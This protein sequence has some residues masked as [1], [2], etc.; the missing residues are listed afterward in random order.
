MHR[1]NLL[2][3]LN[4]YYPTNI[5]EQESKEKIIAFVQQY[6]NCFERTLDIGHITA[7]SWLVSQDNTKALLTHHKKLN[8]WIQ[9]GGHCD[10]ESDTLAVA[11]KEAQEESGIEQIKPMQ[12]SIFDLGVHLIPEYK[13]EKAHYH[14]DIRFLLQAADEKIIISDESHDLLWIEKNIQVLPSLQPSVMR[15]FNKWILI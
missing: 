6:T 14:Y 5:D 15:M 8:M 11:L 2:E 1:N 12:L 4:N 3:L 7:S 13:K 10:G 9:I